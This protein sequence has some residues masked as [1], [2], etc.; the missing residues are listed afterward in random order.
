MEFTLTT[1]ALLSAG[2]IF[3]LR[4]SD[5]TLDTLRVLFV[6]R[7]RRGISWVLGFFQ[8]AIFVLA[9]T[10]VLTNL[11]NPLNIIGY[12]A[13]FATGNV[14]GITIE[15]RLAIGH[16]DLRIIS[17]RR[18]SAIAES[19]RSAG[20]AVT[21]IPAR[22]KDGMVT[23]LAVSVLRK[24]IEQVRASVNSIDPEAFITAEDIRPIR[25]GFWRA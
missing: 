3:L 9:I 6:M 7:G 23:M 22:G 11:D 24:N 10:S 18:G 17:S 1:Q 16:A 19:L 14:L 25:H 20:Y 4:V 21:E 12:A 8:S 5:M 13:G 2:L 15:K